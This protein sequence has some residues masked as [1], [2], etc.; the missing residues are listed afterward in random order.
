MDKSS[1]IFGN[2]MSSKVVRKAEKSKKKFQK[3]F[4]DD[5]QANY[6]MTIEENFK[7]RNLC[8]EI[9]KGK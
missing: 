6:P 1:N 5:S 9:R 3:K 8:S 7:S 4:G 2:V